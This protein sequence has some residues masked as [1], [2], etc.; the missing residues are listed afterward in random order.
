M[1]NSDLLQNCR[2]ISSRKRGA[3]ECVSVS[4]QV[5]ICVCGGEGG[6]VGRVNI[7][8]LRNVGKFSTEESLTKVILGP[9]FYYEIF[10]RRE[11]KST[12]HK[13]LTRFRDH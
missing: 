9:D 4:V 1:E 6:G 11:L 3:H 12:A 5:C 13:L 2:V 7:I 10:R 8:L